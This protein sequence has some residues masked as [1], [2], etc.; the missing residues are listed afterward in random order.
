MKAA[1]TPSGKVATLPKQNPNKPTVSVISEDTLRKILHIISCFKKEIRT[2]SDINK[3][4]Y[5]P[6]GMLVTFWTFIDTDDKQIL[7]QIYK[8]EQTIRDEFPEFLFDFNV[9]FSS[10]EDAP[11]NFITDYLK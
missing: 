10:K 3:I 7:R 9:I 6:K 5:Y 1:C 2:I 8:A 4:A 11:V